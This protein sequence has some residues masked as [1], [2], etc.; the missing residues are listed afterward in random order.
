[1]KSLWMESNFRT[2]WNLVE[3]TC[4]ASQRSNP[5]TLTNNPPGLQLSGAGGDALTP[6]LCAHP[7]VKP[8]HCHGTNLLL[9]PVQ[10]RFFSRSP[11]GTGLSH[12]S[13]K[14]WS[15][16]L[17]PAELMLTF[18]DGDV[19]SSSPSPG[20]AAQPWA[21]GYRGTAAAGNHPSSEVKGKES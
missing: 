17:P 11:S 21:M 7:W 8:S 10:I 20:D 18:H 3:P 4:L 13:E 1:M 12:N 6:S 9:S 15:P 14:S 5:N 16:Y 2:A 19:N